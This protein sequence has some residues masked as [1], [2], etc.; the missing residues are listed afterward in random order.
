MRRELSIV[1][2]GLLI[3]TIVS[4]GLTFLLSTIAPPEPTTDRWSWWGT[5][6]TKITAV[7][8]AG[9]SM[10]WMARRESSR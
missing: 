8:V 9:A 1:L 2:A 3:F 7:V 4:V 6:A 10:A 5:Y